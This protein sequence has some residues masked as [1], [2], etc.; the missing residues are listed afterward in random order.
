M[1]L[2]FVL[3]KTVEYR[4]YLELNGIKIA[5]DEEKTKPFPPVSA[6]GIDFVLQHA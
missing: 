4:K 2:H 3:S 5:R 6:Q 1:F